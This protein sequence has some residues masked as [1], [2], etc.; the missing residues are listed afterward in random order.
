[1]LLLYTS[2]REHLL[3]F[4]LLHKH[5]VCFYIY[6]Y[7]YKRINK[8]RIDNMR[9]MWD[10][11]PTSDWRDPSINHSDLEGLTSILAILNNFNLHRLTLIILFLVSQIIR[12]LV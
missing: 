8:E 9:G 1:M 6:I 5:P 2:N 7:I 11:Y 3:S 4:W 10:D 12:N